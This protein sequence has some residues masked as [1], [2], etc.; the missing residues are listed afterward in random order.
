L[1]QDRRKIEEYGEV[2]EHRQEHR[3]N[4]KKE[5]KEKKRKRRSGSRSRRYMR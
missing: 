4:P 1:S 5:E 2:L 3:I